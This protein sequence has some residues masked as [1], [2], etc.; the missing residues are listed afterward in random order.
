MALD[1]TQDH[2]AIGWGHWT[3]QFADG[4]NLEAVVRGLFQPLND[5]EA[6][7]LQLLNDRW[8]D[9]AVGAQLDGIGQIVGL[10]RIIDDVIYVQFFGF[11]GQPGIA[12]FGEGRMRRN[13]EPV[14]GG[15]TTLLDPEYRK[16]LYWKIAINNG[17]GTTP[18]I[19]AALK[20]IFDVD[21][22]IVQDRGNAKIAVWV[23]RLPGPSDPLLVNARRW[24]PKAA[25]VG[26][27][28]SASTDTPFG[29]LSQGFYGFGV[30]V[31][32]REIQ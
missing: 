8:L 20:P 16:L 7:L 14:T 28:L 32:A 21:R 24:V 3:A 30:G 18:E 6:A 19:I 26:L 22:V 4:T 23:D 13:G 25:G 29:F 11:E 15:S 17:H 2:G 12:G 5:I 9:T 1:L 31:M 10:P 27:I